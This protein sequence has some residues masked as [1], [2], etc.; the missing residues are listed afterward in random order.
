MRVEQSPGL[1]DATQQALA[2][3]LI[4][5]VA[6]GASIGWVRPPPVD[7]ALAFWRR[8]SAGITAGERLGWLLRSD[9]GDLIG[10]VQLLLDQAEN[11]RHRAEVCKL[12]VSPRARRQ[13]GGAALLRAL[14]AEAQRRGRSLLVLDTN[15][16]SAA[17]RL[18]AREGWQVCGV[19]PAYAEQADG[20]LGATTWMFKRLG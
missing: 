9:A 8:V 18:Y 6:A 13:G 2:G 10:S 7:A 19:M 5:C 4:D 12:M 1:D 15:T 11:G 17:Q 16:G 14:E 3:L 20:S